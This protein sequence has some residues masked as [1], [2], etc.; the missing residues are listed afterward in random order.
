M[1][2]EELHLHFLQ[3]HCQY[4]IFYRCLFLLPLFPVLWLHSNSCWDTLWLKPPSVRPIR[5]SVTQVSYPKKITA[6]TTALY[7]FPEVRASTPY[8]PKIL[9]ILVHL[10]WAFLKF[11]TTN[12]QSSS[13]MVK[14]FPRYLNY[15][16]ATSGRSEAWKASAALVWASSSTR[17]WHICSS[18][19]AHIT[20][21]VWRPFRASKGTNMS[22]LV[23]HGWCRLP[24]SRTTIL[25]CT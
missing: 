18:H 16:T 2:A 13:E 14:T 22:H 8:W 3:S 5:G 11:E 7:K 9:D 20:L 24:S 15:N 23:H 1:V 4:I 12:S 21:D 6:C 17:R 10:F 25:S 19:L